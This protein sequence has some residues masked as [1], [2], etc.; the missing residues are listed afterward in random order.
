MEFLKGLVDGLNC[1]HFRDTGDTPPAEL[2][3]LRDVG[4]SLSRITFYD[5]VAVLEFMDV[6]RD[7]PYRQ[8]F[9]GGETR[10]M[11]LSTLFT[12]GP[13]SH[14]DT[15]LVGRTAARHVERVLLERISDLL[16]APERSPAAEGEALRA[17]SA[18]N[19]ALRARLAA[20]ENSSSWQLTAPV[21]LL[22]RLFGR[23][24]S[25]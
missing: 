7:T 24:A 2:A 13:R 23:G 17:L 10:V 16:T 21:R 9:T 8:V 4:R 25:G 20:M 14:A 12:V 19:E 15:R 6:P 1:D 22:G 5:S 18:E 3:H 11:P